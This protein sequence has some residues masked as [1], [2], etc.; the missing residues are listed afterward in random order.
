MGPP[1]TRVAVTVYVP[2]AVTE[3]TV[4]SNERVVVAPGEGHGFASF[5]RAHVFGVAVRGKCP[6][7]WASTDA[8]VPRMARTA[9]SGAQ[10]RCKDVM[11]P[12]ASRTTARRIPI[13]APSKTPFSTTR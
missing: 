9:K 6:E 2:A 3:N 5:S 11:S 13:E 7:Y 8:L 10:K 12:L 4:V 1:P